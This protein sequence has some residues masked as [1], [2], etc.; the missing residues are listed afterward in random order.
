MKS[1]NGT[2]PITVSHPFNEIPVRVDV[3]VKVIYNGQEYIFPGLGSIQRDDDVRTEY[4]GVAY[5][6]NKTSVMLFVPKGKSTGRVI[7]TG[8]S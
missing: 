4:G 3:Q 7:Y 6:Y 2:S 5:T 8:N 1:I